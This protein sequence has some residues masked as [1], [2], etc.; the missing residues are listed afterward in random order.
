MIKQ[1]SWPL[2][3]RP[4]LVPSVKQGL[5]WW[6]RWRLH[7]QKVYNKG[8]RF[9]LSFHWTI[10][11]SL[12][13]LMFA[14]YGCKMSAPTL[15]IISSYWYLIYK[16]IGLKSAGNTLPLLL[17]KKSFPEIYAITPFRDIWTNDQGT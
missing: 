15:D 10:V 9:F 8:T 2:C 14:T 12:A 4:L 13:F 16:Y 5:Y 17:A 6:S 7:T 1:A 3:S 11:N